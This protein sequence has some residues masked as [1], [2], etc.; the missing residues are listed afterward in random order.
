MNIFGAFTF[1][2]LIK[3][4]LPGFV[5]L[6]AIV[7]FEADISQWAGHEPALWNYAKTKDQA[8]LVLAI[9]ASLLLGLLSNIVVFMGVNDRLVRAPVKR[10][11]PGLCALYEM[12]AQRVRD[13]YWEGLRGADQAFRNSF[14]RSVDPE[15]GLLQVLGTEK[16]GYVR[17]Q[18][19]YHLEFQLNL[20][21]SVGAIALALSVSVLLNVASVPLRAFLSAA[22]AAAAALVIW[23]LLLAARKNYARHLAKMATVMAVA[24]H[25]SEPQKPAG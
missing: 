20:L 16:L 4:F 1:G 18:H 25:Q 24:L 13:R 2:S 17:E 15:L 7:M 19:W 23:G 14:D 21:L 12:L 6:L 8:A 22:C 10:A 5:W 3:T 9:P 11:G